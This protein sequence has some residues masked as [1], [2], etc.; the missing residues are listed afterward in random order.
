LLP[1]F[2]ENVSVLLTNY[3]TQIV[4][5]LFSSP[6]IT[7]TVNSVVGVFAQI[8]AFLEKILVPIAKWLN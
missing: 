8:A 4:E 7:N 5:K 1:L 3:Y 2:Q 6:M